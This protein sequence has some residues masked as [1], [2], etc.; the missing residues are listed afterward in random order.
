MAQGDKEALDIAYLQLADDSPGM[1]M[2][3]VD[4]VRNFVVEH[5]GTEAKQV[6]IHD[7]YWLPL[8][9]L[10]EGSEPCIRE[11]LQDR[12]MPLDGA[13]GVYTAFTSWWTRQAGDAGEPQAEACLSEIAA[14]A[15]HRQSTGP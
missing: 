10:S 5:F 12:G 3:A 7:R 1:P 15:A 13:G 14:F 4:L 11:F 9:Q 2:T 6:E 8:E